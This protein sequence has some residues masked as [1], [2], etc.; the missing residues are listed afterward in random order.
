MDAPDS[1]PFDWDAALKLV[2]QRNKL[3]DALIEKNTS[4][5]ISYSDHAELKQII[6]S[7]PADLVGK[8]DEFLSAAENKMHARFRIDALRLLIVDEDTRLRINEAINFLP[9]FP[10]ALVSD[11]T[12]KRMITGL[13]HYQQLPRSNDYSS[14]SPVIVAQCNALLHIACALLHLF[15][16]EDTELTFAML[17]NE[18][19]TIADQQLA[20]LAL[21]RPEQ[22]EI[23]RDCI[24]QRGHVNVQL[25]HEMLATPAPS[26]TE[27]IL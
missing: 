3:F 14:E 27:G 6:Q 1:D 26:L 22:G 7:Y 24:I 13:H 8:I 21:S 23:I 5:N 20:E 18:D 12:A 16:I 4:Y 15:N 2:K 9:L 11:D 10:P 17:F 19:S 25:I